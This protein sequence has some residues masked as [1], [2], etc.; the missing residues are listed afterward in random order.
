MQLR[1]FSGLALKS[2]QRTHM[3]S[4]PLS[5]N[6]SSFINHRSLSSLDDFLKSMK[7]E[8]Q[9]STTKVETDAKA[10]TSE[11]KVTKENV[12]EEKVTEEKVSGEKS[13]EN[14]ENKEAV[15]ETSTEKPAGQAFDIN[16][17]TSM[18]SSAFQAIKSIDL[19]TVK[20]SVVENVS[21][22]YNELLGKKKSSLERKVYQAESYRPTKE[23]TEEDTE[24]APAYDGPS[25]IV[26]VKGAK[27]SWESMKDRLSES[28]I[29]QQMLKSSKKASQ[30]IGETHVGKKAQAVNQSVKDRVEDIREVWE[31]SQNPIIYT[32][33]GI[34]DNIAGETEESQCLRTIRNLDPE[35]VLEDWCEEVKNDFAPHI[36]SAHLNGN[37]KYLK[38][39]CGEGVYNRLA[40]DIRIRKSE[41][42]VFDPTILDFD[43]LQVLLKY[44]DREGPIIM[45]VYM[46]QQINCV[47]NKDGEIIEVSFFLI[48]FPIFSAFFMIL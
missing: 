22:G 27:S 15:G 11:P 33:S 45:C 28:P 44:V 47:K 8:A 13:T 17:V 4:T 14:V 36:I 7:D 19:K 18:F 38:K 46:V 16:K 9:K 48:F 21:E 32:L 35:F 40:A 26:E 2:V 1:R 30:V 6:K 42:I 31:T 24:Q 5:F 34:W 39:H 12:T 43:Q 29:I 10:P 41:G 20:S 3:A 37:T 23:D 25:S